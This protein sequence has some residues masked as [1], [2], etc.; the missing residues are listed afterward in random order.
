MTL[1]I[2]PHNPKLTK[3]TKANFIAEVLQ[4]KSF[5]IIDVF[6]PWCKPCQNMSP[7]FDKLT[8]EYPNIKFATINIDEEEELATALE[9]TT[10]PTF[11]IFHQGKFVTGFVGRKSYDEF[12]KIIN[13]VLLKKSK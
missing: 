13:S 12:K 4:N 10:V 9:V 1:Q 11:I 3:I 8:E 7:I 2:M 6:A 5:V